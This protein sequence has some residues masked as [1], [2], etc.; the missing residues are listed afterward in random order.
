MKPIA[1]TIRIITIPPISAL[2]LNI[3]IYFAIPG[4]FDHLWELFLI[5]LVTGLIP[6]LAY[7]VQLKTHI[8]RETGERDG[9]RKL[10]IIFSMVSYSI[11]LFI[12]IFF[13]LTYIQTL[14]YVTYFFSGVFM[15]LFN[16]ILQIRASGHLCGICGPVAVLIYTL[17]FQYVFLLGIILLVIWSSIYLKRH[18]YSEMI[19]GAIIPI[20]SMFLSM[21]ILALLN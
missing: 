20:A 5:I 4:S 9:E 12:A 13:H 6:V 1:K 3:I 17:G 10:A 11:G 15:V 14:I 16:F 2:L 7:P 21:G 18:V 8:I 19:V